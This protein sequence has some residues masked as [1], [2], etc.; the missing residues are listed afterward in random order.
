M[1]AAMVHV[2]WAYDGWVYLLLL[3]DWWGPLSHRPSATKPITSHKA[4]WPFQGQPCSV[5]AWTCPGILILTGMMAAMVHVLWAYD[6]WVNITPLAD[7]LRDPGR[8]IPRSLILGIAT[9]IAV[10]LG[11]TLAYHFVLPLSEVA[12]ANK[13]EGGIENAVAAVSCRQLLGGAGVVAIS[14]LV[15][16][17]TFI[18][19]N[20]NALTGPRAY[21]AMAR[22]GLLTRSLCRVHPRFRTPA[23]AVLAQGLWATLLTVAGTALIVVP[24]PSV[25][26]GA[27]GFLLAPILDAWTKLNQTPLYDL[28]LT[29][30]IFGANL[31]YLLAITSV[32]V[33]RIK[34]PDLPRPYRTWGNP[35]TPL[36]Y[37]AA[38]V[39]LLGNMLVDLQSRVQALAG[40]GLILLGI[41]AWALL[42][43][44]PPRT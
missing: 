23:N 32:F 26:V 21:F 25:S 19:L 38:A 41:P 35:Y 7:E 30:V 17:S 3:I 28:L 6:G 11:M 40:I 14:L 36:L 31:F 37:V 9:L 15:M 10:Y 33:L 13:E 34:Q 2:L 4:V 12:A 16:C 1:M 8:N 27:P 43:R 24:P 5:P 44:P 39:L 20:G 18:S 42:R 29:Y 22:D